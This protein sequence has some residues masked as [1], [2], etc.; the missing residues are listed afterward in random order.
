MLLNFELDWQ[1][2][3]IKSFSRAFLHFFCAKRTGQIW[4]ILSSRWFY[5][6]YYVLIFLHHSLSTFFS[7]IQPRHICNKP[8]KFGCELRTPKGAGNICVSINFSEISFIFQLGCIVFEQ[9]DP[10]LKRKKIRKRGKV[11]GGLSSSRSLQFTIRYPE[12]TWKK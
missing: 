10:N 4:W 7:R 6:L 5:I 1:R 9:K 2:L 11:G 3:R 8:H 12:K